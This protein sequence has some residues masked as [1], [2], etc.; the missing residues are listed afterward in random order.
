[1]RSFG[2]TTCTNYFLFLFANWSR[3]FQCVRQGAT[4]I[5]L[6]IIILIIILI[7]LMWS[8][9]KKIKSDDSFRGPISD[10]RWVSRRIVLSFGSYLLDPRCCA[11]PRRSS[12]KLSRRKS[13]AMLS[14]CPGSDLDGSVFHF[15]AILDV[16][17]I[18]SV[19][20]TIDTQIR[21]RSL[22]HL[23]VCYHRDVTSQFFP[24]SL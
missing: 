5:S 13:R 2:L 9:E 1:M 8:V 3:Y 12:E 21:G 22:E 11:K 14:F 18:T 19:P 20:H 7:I 10:H 4:S 17:N 23:V 15:S 6:K 16:S 24:S